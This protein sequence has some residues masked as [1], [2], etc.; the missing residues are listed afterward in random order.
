VQLAEYFIKNPDVKIIFNA[1]QKVDPMVFILLKRLFNITRS[2]LINVAAHENVF[3]KH[4]IWPCKAPNHPYLWRKAL[5]LVQSS[6]SERSGMISA[7]PVR[8][9]I[10]ISRNGD[11]KGKTKDIIRNAARRIPNEDELLQELR[12]YLRN[13]RN[14]KEELVS[15]D[16]LSF[17]I[18]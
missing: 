16:F 11:K 4:F 17:F 12:D 5:E 9:V 15:S 10:W 1:L 14:S 6:L 2:Q 3:A 7:R 8:R 13:E 18:L